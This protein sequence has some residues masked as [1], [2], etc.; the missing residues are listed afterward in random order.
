MI[1]SIHVLE[2]FHYWEVPDMLREW[3]RALKPGGK[4]ILELPCMDKIIHYMAECLKQRQPMDLQMTWLALWGDPAYKREE[5]CHK[6]GY[7]KS[8]LVQLL[9]D[10]GFV[11]VAVE[12]PRYHVVVRDMRVVGYKG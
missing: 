11:N 7:L 3:K 4:L 1:I 9:E 2:H 8:Q 10:L 12:K 6:W 5:M